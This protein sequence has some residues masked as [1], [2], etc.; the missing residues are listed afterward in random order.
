[1]RA[2][3][4]LRKHQNEERESFFRPLEAQ[5]TTA[6]GRALSLNFAALPKLLLLAVWLAGGNSFVDAVQKVRGE[7]N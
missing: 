4:P 6:N 2:R 3:Q 1:V 5:I 7:N